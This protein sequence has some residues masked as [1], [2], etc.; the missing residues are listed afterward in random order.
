MKI[1]GTLAL[2]AALCLSALG[3]TNTQ[4]G[5]AWTPSAS[6]ITGPTNTTVAPD[7]YQVLQSIN[8]AAP[9]STWTYV[10]ST[11]AIYVSGTNFVASTNCFLPVS[12]LPTS[13]CYFT[14]VYTNG[15]GSSPPSNFAA[16]QG[17]P[18]SVGSLNGKFVP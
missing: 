14:I 8:V 7:G 9:L 18:Q 4:F 17:L 11:P 10:T 13:A 6:V 2:F 3:Q 12:I 15:R 16:A 1:L 5:L